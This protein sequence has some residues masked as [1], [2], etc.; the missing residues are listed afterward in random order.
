MIEIIGKHERSLGSGE[1]NDT[2]LW[3]NRGNYRRT[4]WKQIGKYKGCK[5]KKLRRLMG[6]MG[7]HESRPKGI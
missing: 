7:K 1:S 5:G 6:L 3:E 2:S 4:S